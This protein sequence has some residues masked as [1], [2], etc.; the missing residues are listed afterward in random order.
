[1]EANDGICQGCGQRID[2]PKQ[3]HPIE[4]CTSFK[5]GIRVIIDLLHKWSNQPFSHDD[6]VK[7]LD[8]MGID[9]HK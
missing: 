5:A 4:C 7:E 3:Y 8:D 9:W 6:F 1:M 2:N